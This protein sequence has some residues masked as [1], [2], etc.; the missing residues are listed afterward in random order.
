MCVLSVV[1][2]MMCD[3]WKSVVWCII[4]LCMFFVCVY[5]VSFVSLFVGVSCVYCVVLFD[6]MIFWYGVCVMMM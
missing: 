6:L 3:V 1:Y 4:L 2:V 5:V